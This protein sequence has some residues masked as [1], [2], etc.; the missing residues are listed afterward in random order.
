MNAYSKKYNYL[1]RWNGKSGCSY[2]RQLFL[3]LHES[4]LKE[5]PRNKWHDIHMDFPLTQE[6]DLKNVTKLVLVRNPYT[7]VVS[8]F[9]NKYCGGEGHNLLSKKIKLKKCTFKN[10]VYKLKELKDINKLNYY[11][12]HIREQ[13]YNCKI[14]EYTN[15]IKLESFNKSIK[16]IYSKNKNLRA[17]LPKVLNYFSNEDKFIKN[18]TVRTNN[19][20]KAF[21]IEYSVNDTVFPDWKTFYNNELRKLVNKIYKNDFLIFGYSQKI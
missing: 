12:I 7:R 18:K 15:I 6:V 16:N 17:L 5:K 8:M 11:D 20:S 21:D 14:D 1:I 3:Y 9:C 4:E 10:F 2:F 13:A 19:V